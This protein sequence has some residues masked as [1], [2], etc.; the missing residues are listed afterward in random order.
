M[1]F[2]AEQKYFVSVQIKAFPREDGNIT[3]MPYFGDDDIDPNVEQSKT[4]KLKV[5]DIPYGSLSAKP[6]ATFTDLLK[7][8]SQK[9]PSIPQSDIAKYEKFVEERVGNRSRNTL[10]ETATEIS[11]LDILR[12]FNDYFY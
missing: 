6:I 4:E 5:V 10:P 3:Y 12:L 7:V 9:R 2:F 11:C 8:I 1:K